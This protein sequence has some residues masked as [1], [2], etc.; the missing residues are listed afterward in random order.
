MLLYIILEHV[1]LVMLWD[2]VLQLMK[3]L[4]III[5]GA[6]SVLNHIKTNELDIVNLRASPLIYIKNDIYIL[7]DITRPHQYLEQYRGLKQQLLEQSEDRLRDDI[8]QEIKYHDNK[9]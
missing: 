1:Y 8:I 6:K 3:Y 2:L 9:V 5:Q 7:T 4:I